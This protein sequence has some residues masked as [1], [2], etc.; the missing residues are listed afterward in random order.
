M[1]RMLVDEVEYDSDLDSDECITDTD[2]DDEDGGMQLPAR[3]RRFLS[4]SLEEHAKA[5]R[6]VQLQQLDDDDDTP[7]LISSS[8]I[9]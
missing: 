2:S 8:D 5:V 4:H 6:E 9:K 7:E 1:S 3:R